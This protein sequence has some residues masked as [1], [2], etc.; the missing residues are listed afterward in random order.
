MRALK[1]GVLCLLAFNAHANVIQ[2]F[3]G[4]SYANPADLFKVK[5]NEFII[6]ANGSYADLGFTG[7]ALNFNTFQYESGENHS[8]TQTLMGYGRIAQRVTDKLV[9]GVDVTEPF[10]SN[11]NWGDDAFTRYAN[12]QNLLIDVDVDPRFSFSISKKIQVGAGVDLNFL[13]N[14]EVNWA[15]PT[16]P[17]SYSTLIN[18]TTGFGVGF[19]L[20]LTY[21][22]NQTNFLGV[23]FYS[24]I[25][26]K[27]TGYSILG[28]NSTNMN[29]SFN[30]PATTIINYVH[31]FN[32]KW[33]VSFT[34]FESQWDQNQY[35]RLFNTAS[36]PPNQDFVFPMLFRKSYALL[37]VLR[38]QYNDKLGLALAG[39]VDIGPESDN[40]RSIT[41]PSYQQYF[42]GGVA[43]YHFNKSTSVELLYGYVYSDP[44]IRNRVP[45]PTGSIPLTTGNVEINVN[46]IDLRLKIQK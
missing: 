34:G 46:I 13:A 43:D 44:P 28:N 20:G 12:T 26:Q 22:I 16:G 9:I 17:T 6:G 15:L 30:L 19:N 40:L 31:I 14:N 5:K 32:P 8:R 45:L 7:S 4:L 1:T 2:Y 25:R 29:F 24:K 11:L 41:F 42:I 37:G 36:P 21:V 33:L 10:N 23:T 27:T 3:T 18:K 38:H 39:L 35:I